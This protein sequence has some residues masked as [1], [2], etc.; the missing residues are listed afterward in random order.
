M[1]KSQIERA[2]QLLDEEMRAHFSYLRLFLSIRTLDLRAL[3]AATDLAGED[4][5]RYHPGTT[6]CWRC[7][8]EGAILKL[9][10]QCIPFMREQRELAEAMVEFLEADTANGML[11]A[12]I[13]VWALRGT[14]RVGRPAAR[15][16]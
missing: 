7:A 15:I 3:N 10:Q 4:A 12:M 13:K 14:R 8:K 1:R 2:T 6:A 11:T 16:W 9:L 5:V